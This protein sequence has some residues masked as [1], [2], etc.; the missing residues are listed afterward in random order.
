MNIF[1][2]T[3]VKLV[4][5]SCGKRPDGHAFG[6]VGEMTESK[7]QNHVL[8]FMLCVRC[9]AVVHR[10]PDGRM[11]NVPLWHPDQAHFSSDRSY[12]AARRDRRGETPLWGRR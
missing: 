9:G 2:R 3:M 8:D 11:R 4:Q 5:W 12:D 10:F 6:K 7:T 1:R